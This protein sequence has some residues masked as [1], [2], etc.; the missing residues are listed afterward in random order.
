[1][2]NNIPTANIS[3]LEEISAMHNH[4]ITNLSFPASNMDEAN[5][6]S[7]VPISDVGER[8]LLEHLLELGHRRISYIYSVV[9]RDF[10]S[11][12]LQ[13]C[14]RAHSKIYLLEGAN[15]RRV[16]VG[17][18]NA[19]ERAFS[20]KQAEKLI[21]FDDEQ[22]WNYYVREYE[23]VK[24]LAT[25]EVALTDVNVTQAEILLEELPLMQE[26]QRSK[27]ALTIFINTDVTAATV[28]IVIHTDY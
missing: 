8:L 22:A 5:I 2:L 10:L 21:V 26:V 23:L 14:L 11:D 3:L 12:C 1:M 9:N 13:T 27:T 16:I 6:D 15:K 25:N 20:G 7:I 19:S 24:Q 28:P 17:S 4:H 18:A